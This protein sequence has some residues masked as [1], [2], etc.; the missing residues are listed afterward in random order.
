MIIE[1]V[2]IAS[3]LV[4][5]LCMSFDNYK[6]RRIVTLLQFC[7]RDNYQVALKTTKAT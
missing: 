1:I 4:R 2:F 3:L 6:I 5:D 7:T